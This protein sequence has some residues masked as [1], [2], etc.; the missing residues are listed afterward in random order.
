L[1]LP[2]GYNKYCLI[3]PLDPD[4]PIQKNI[5]YVKTDNFKPNAKVL[6]L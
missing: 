4:I 6:K 5:F 2:L 3:E 1:T